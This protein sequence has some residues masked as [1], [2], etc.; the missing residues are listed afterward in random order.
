MNYLI[1]QG[2]GEFNYYYFFK[3]VCSGKM[4]RESTTVN[5]G[6]FGTRGEGFERSYN[7]FTLHHMQK[8]LNRVPTLS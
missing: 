5:W 6:L 8:F 2:D 1:P 7:L 3:N 4:T